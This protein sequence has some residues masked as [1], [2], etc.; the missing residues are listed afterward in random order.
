MNS[1]LFY[2]QYSN[3]FIPKVKQE[4]ECK[5]RKGKV[6]LLLANIPSHPSVEN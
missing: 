1:E 6:M 2:E 5:G 4:R 3:E